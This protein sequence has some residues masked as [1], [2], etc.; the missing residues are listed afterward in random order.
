MKCLIITGA[1]TSA[2]TD[3][4]FMKMLSPGPE[5]SFMGSPT[6][7]PMTAAAWAGLPL[8]PSSPDSIYYLALSHVL[9][10]FP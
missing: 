2:V 7:S 1:N 8:P 10:T 9:P 5:E 4:S 3:I 6:V